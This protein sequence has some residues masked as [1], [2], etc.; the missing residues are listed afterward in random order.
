MARPCYVYL[1]LKMPGPKGVIAMHGDRE[2]AIECEEGDASFAESACAVEE[3]KA[4]KSQIDPND[5]SM[6]ILPTAEP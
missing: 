1:K 2:K 5:M 4:Y 6:V 3:L